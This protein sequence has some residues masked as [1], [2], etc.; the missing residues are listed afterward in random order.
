MFERNFQEICRKFQKNGIKIRKFQNSKGELKKHVTKEIGN[1]EDEMNKIKHQVAN[2]T[3][4]RDRSHSESV[5][6]ERQY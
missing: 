1:L 6:Y 4:I 3:V 5:Q 2:K